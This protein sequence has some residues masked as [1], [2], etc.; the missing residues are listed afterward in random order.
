L[1]DLRLATERGELK[2]QYQPQVDIATGRIV[3]F[4]ALA[5]WH[6]PKLGVLGPKLFVPIAEESGIILALGHWVIEEVCRQIIEW[7][8]DGFHP[9]SI[10]INVSA[11]QLKTPHFGDKLVECLAKWR[12]EPQAIELELTESALMETT[13]AHRGVIDHLR[14]LGIALSIDDFGT[15]Y[16]SLAYLRSYQV[17]H[18]K[19]PQTFI[20]EIYSD[21]NDFIIVRAIVSLGYELG[22]SVI[23]EG[24]ETEM[25]LELLRQAGCRYVQGFLFSPPVSGLDA[26]KLM[27]QEIL[28]PRP[29]P[30][31]PSPTPPV[32]TP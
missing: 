1:Q 9:P 12:V 14:F 2:L 21:S 17:S 22:I 6:H 13:Q 29:S 10:A 7:R 19:I 32:T 8:D 11:E 3:G 24:V 15:G 16:S 27:Q 26:G 28:S 4:E 5:R 23:A 18:I 20:D 30:P 31:T 25:Q